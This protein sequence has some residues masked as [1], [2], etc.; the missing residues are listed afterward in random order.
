MSSFNSYG[1]E[2][3][4][5][6]RGNGTNMFRTDRLSQPRAPKPGDTLANG[7]RIWSEPRDGGNGAVLIDDFDIPA[8]IPIALQCETNKAGRV[9][10]LPLD[11]REA[12]VLATGEMVLSR[13]SPCQGDRVMLHLEGGCSGAHIS[14]PERFPIALQ[15]EAER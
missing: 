3:H 2:G 7:I 11:L 9:A 12:D 8:R 10:V 6:N 13:P 1:L 5:R 14:V 4:R 15:T